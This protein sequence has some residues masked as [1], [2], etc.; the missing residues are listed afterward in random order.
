MMRDCHLNTCP[1]GVATQDPEAAQ[2][3]HR[4]ARSTSSTSCA[5]SPQEVR[6]LMAELGFRTIDEMV[7]RVR[8]ARDAARRRPLEGA[9]PRLQPDP[10]T[11][12]RSPTTYGRTCT[13]RAGPRPRAVA[14]RDDAPRRSRS[15]R[16]RSGEAGP[17]RRCRSATR[18]APSARCSGT[19]SPASYGAE[20][21]ARTTPSSSTSRARP[22]RA[23]A[24]S[25]RAGMT[26]ELEGDANDYVGK[27]LSGG[28]IV[29]YPPRDVDVRAGGEHHHR[30]R[31]A[32]RR[33]RRRG[34]HPRRRRRALRGP[35]LR[36][37]TPS[38]RASATT[39]AST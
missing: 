1:V 29:V 12:R 28:R 15:P 24:R 26:L 4:R 27:G 6:E 11:S 21:A 14:R 17:R 35:Q 25:S 10:A 18:T 36:R 33:D 3:V 31:R 34:V 8:S 38:S 20:R 2:E 30:Q 37:R 32:L 13:D 22:A 7:G 9:R 39:A 23:S 16:S 5:S 19:R